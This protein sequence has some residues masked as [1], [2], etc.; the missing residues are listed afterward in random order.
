[1]RAAPPRFAALALSALAVAW[2]GRTVGAGAGAAQAGHG[3]ESVPTVAAQ[4][5]EGDKTAAAVSESAPAERLRP[6][7]LTTHPHDPGAF[8]QGL[9]LHDGWLYESTGRDRG[10]AR[11]RQVDPLTGVAAREIALP[12]APDGGSYWGEGLAL[13]GTRLIQLTWLHGVAFEYDLAT[14]VETR[15]FA[16][17]GEGWGLCHDGKRLIMSDGSAMLTFRDA[18]TFEVMG[19]VVVTDAFGPVARLNELE[20]VG[21]DVYANV[22]TTDDIVRID[23]RSGTVTAW[24]D[25]SGLLSPEERAGA[26]V[27]NGIA[28]DDRRDTFLITGKWWPRLFEVVFVPQAGPGPGLAYLPLAQRPRAGRL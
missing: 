11:L 27:L 25:A 16:Y 2:I 10:E 8:T 4:R 17:Q 18:A 23:P 15:R 28:Y 24:I 19:Q 14:F 5:R 12:P 9:L 7:V 1:M 13:A 6:L 26:N 20:C 3:P 21:G 22:F